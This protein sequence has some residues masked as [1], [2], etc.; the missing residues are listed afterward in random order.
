MRSALGRLVKATVPSIGVV[1]YSEIGD[2][3][4]I[5]VIANIDLNAHRPNGG[6]N[7]EEFH[8]AFATNR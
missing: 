4:D 3:L 2:H 1:S 8:D 7:P 6:A 5:E